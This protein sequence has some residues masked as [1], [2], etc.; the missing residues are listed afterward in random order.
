MLFDGIYQDEP[1]KKGVRICALACGDDGKAYTI[2]VWADYAEMEQVLAGKNRSYLKQ[3]ALVCRASTVYAGDTYTT[4]AFGTVAKPDA[5]RGVLSAWDFRRLM[6]SYTGTAG[7][8]YDT[9]IIKHRSGELLPFVQGKDD[10]FLNAF[11]L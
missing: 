4:V 8:D 11:C 1:A 7:K 9:Y 6:S 3:T 10:P 2:K 5:E